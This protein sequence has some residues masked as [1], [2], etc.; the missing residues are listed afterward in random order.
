MRKIHLCLICVVLIT[1][2][3]IGCGQKNHTQDESKKSS[4]IEKDSE[5][6]ISDVKAFNIQDF[7]EEIELFSLGKTVSK[8]TN[9]TDLYKNAKK[10]WQYEKFEVTAEYGIDVYYDSEN[11]AWMAVA[12]LKDLDPERD[13]AVPTAIIRSDG[14][15]L[16]VWF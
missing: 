4:T 3:L 5:I 1:I 2:T 12:F 15:V 9:A 13:T 16:A 14:T 10:L 8:I 6:I 11:D 7:Q